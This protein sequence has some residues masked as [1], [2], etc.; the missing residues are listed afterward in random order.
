ML[1]R[2]IRISYRSFHFY[3]YINPW[4]SPVCQLFG[5][6]T[7]QT[8][9]TRQGC[10]SAFSYALSP[11]LEFSPGRYFSISTTIIIEAVL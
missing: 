11:S 6:T 5:Y 8:V 10:G 1:H 3:H 7:V 4:R 2:A 9:I